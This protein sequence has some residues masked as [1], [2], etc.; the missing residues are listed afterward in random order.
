M[1]ITILPKVKVSLILLLVI[2]IA[3]YAGFLSEM[4]LMVLTISLHEIGHIFWIRLFKGKVN[5][6]E[7]GFFGG[8]I[9]VNIDK[10]LGYFC[11]TLI[12][13]GGSNC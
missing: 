13:L 8:N 6:I 4:L 11:K 1:T 5:E 10:N 12:N 7:L 2:I 3:G 9:N